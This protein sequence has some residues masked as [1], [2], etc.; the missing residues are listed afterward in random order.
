[1]KKIRSISISNEIDELLE[2]D[3]KMRGLTV[4]ANLSRI[5]FEHLSNNKKTIGKKLGII[6]K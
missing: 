6:Q 3:S 4:S 5:L 1:M 2:K